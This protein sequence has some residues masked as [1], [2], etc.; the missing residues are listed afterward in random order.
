MHHLCNRLSPEELRNDLIE[1]KKL[2]ESIVGSSVVGYRAP[3][4]SISRET[5]RE[6]QGC[7]YSYDS[8]YNSFEGHG[9]YGHV[10]FTD[11]I[12]QENIYKLYETFCEIPISNMSL[13]GRIIPWGG[14]GYF[15]LMPSWLFHMGVRQ[16]LKKEG[17]FL[18]YTHPW[19]FDPLQPRV[20]NIPLSYKFRHYVNLRKTKDKLMAFIKAFSHCEFVSCKTFLEKNNPEFL[21]PEIQ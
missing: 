9:R 13:G 8:S 1:S 7:G 15:R 2:I 18:F 12:K 21:V 16:I 11:T 19:E 20:D 4:F 5:L 3:S 6:I 14:G 17:V 10:D